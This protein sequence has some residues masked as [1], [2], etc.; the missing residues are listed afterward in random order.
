M[1]GGTCQIAVQ[2]WRITNN[3]LANH[4]ADADAAS[5]VCTT[6]ETQMINVDYPGR[7]SRRRRLGLLVAATAAA[8]S[9]ALAG[10]S[11]GGTTP[12][13][14]PSTSAGPQLNVTLPPDIAA[15]KTIAIG[16]DPTYPPL[17]YL[18]TDGKTPIG[19]NI[20]LLNA[21]A[22]LLGVTITWTP[23]AFA[24]ELAALQAGHFQA[25]LVYSDSADRENGGYDLVD[26]LSVGN[27]YA[28]KPSDPNFGQTPELPCGESVGVN[29]GNVGQQIAPVSSQ[30]CVDAGKQPFDIVTFP[31]ADSLPTALQS[32][33]VQAILN[34]T[35]Y[36]GYLVS[37]SNGAIK[38]LGKPIQQVPYGLVINKGDAVGPV[39]VQA[40]Q[41]LM[42][43]G[44]Y[45]Q[46]LDDYGLGDIALT[47]AGLNLATK[48]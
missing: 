47:K 21:A 41:A 28:V 11:A 13:A 4:T 37:Q 32:N 1:T 23:T 15:S 10:C 30:Q 48:S 39:L 25:G 26:Y 20:D 8:S 27:T 17:E 38:T 36:I 35:V 3:S 6:L 16:L 2:H 22:S 45:Q 18:D 29:T 9:L 14:T 43:N 5:H 42:D 12:T 31:S 7:V 34:S 33:R 44:T 19:L 24:G 40:I 46:I